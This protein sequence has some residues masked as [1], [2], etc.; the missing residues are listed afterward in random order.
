MRNLDKIAE[1][2][3]EKIR[4]RF[5]NISLG[6]KSSASTQNPQDARF[7]NFNYV[8]HE[9]KN[10]GNVSISIVDSDALK[11]FYGKN[12]SH[13]MDDQEKREWFYFLKNI[14]QFAKRNMLTFDTR[15]IN[16][17]NLT[18]KDINQA[19]KHDGTYQV[20]D[21]KNKIRESYNPLRGNSKKSY[22]QIGSVKLTVNHSAAIDE[23]KHGSRSRNI[24]SIFFETSDGE[25]F[26]SPTNSLTGARAFAQHIDNG[27][28][29]Y[30]ERAVCIHEMISEMDDMKTFVRS[31]KH[32]TFEDVTTQGMVEAAIERFYEVKKNLKRSSGKRGYA[33]FWGSYT[34]EPSSELSDI[35]ELKER[36]VKKSFDDRLEKALPHV[37]RAYNNRKN[38]TMNNDMIENFEGWMNETVED[39]I[40]RPEK[41]E[42]RRKG[43]SANELGGSDAWYHRGFIPNFYGFEEESEDYAEYK[44]GY[45]SMIDHAGEQGGKDYG[46]D[47]SL[48]EGTWSI[49][50]T[51]LQLDK[52]QELMNSPLEAGIDGE[53]A[54]NEL[55]D[56]IGSDSLFDEIETI[57]KEDS[58]TDVR[59]FVYDWIMENQPD[60]KEKIDF[61]EMFKSMEVQDQPE[62]QD[63][64]E[65]N[66]HDSEFV[67]KTSRHERLR[68]LAKR[69]GDKEKFDFH[70]AEIEKLYGKKSPPHAGNTFEEQCDDSDLDDIKKLSGI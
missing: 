38:S 41:F 29:M 60:L 31:M 3:F 25:R 16:R 55:Y 59:I 6:D 28:N 9:G 7:F 18:F 42:A 22:Q 70:N 45:D 15:D 68:D 36:F 2:L 39:S 35:S 63:M 4:T 53:N 47:E 61:T 66:Y 69:Q 67:E 10:F 13:G 37:F 56:I 44:N 43:K 64:T 57:A 19:A 23:E 52:L 54:T 20:S 30:D 1:R 32:K 5:D 24:D 40:Y 26:K 17:A 46:V 50:E 12:I 11:I 62:E 14:R 58:K 33:A 8:S 49:P 65:S 34:P 51:H 27:G 48:S 21:I